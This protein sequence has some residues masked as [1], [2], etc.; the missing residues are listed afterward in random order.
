MQ[1]VGT[2]IHVQI[3][4]N[5]V[6]C[7]YSIPGSCSNPPL[8]LRFF[9][10]LFP[11]VV[12]PQNTI[13]DEQDK[14]LESVEEG[15]NDDKDAQIIDP[16][17]ARKEHRRNDKPHP[18]DD[19]NDERGTICQTPNFEEQEMDAEQTY[20]VPYII[21]HGTEHNLQ[22]K[23]ENGCFSQKIEESSERVSFLVP[24]LVL[25]PELVQCRTGILQ[26]NSESFL[27]TLIV[28]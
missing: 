22:Y 21:E 11:L 13:G 12:R 17:S 10:K 20:V 7:G 1:Q 19:E 14:T 5:H 2:K 4:H 3:L 9:G 6:I 24:E 25:Q 26:F 8:S 15:H 28:T 23:D 18:H 27:H 16:A